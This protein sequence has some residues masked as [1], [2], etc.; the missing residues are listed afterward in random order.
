MSHRYE[1]AVLK[2]MAL[3]LLN[4][5][6]ALCSSAQPLQKLFDTHYP[7]CGIAHILM[8]TPP[9]Q[10]TSGENVMEC[11]AVFFS[12]PKELWAILDRVRVLLRT[13]DGRLELR[14]GYLTLGV[15]E[16]LVE[17]V[18]TWGEEGRERITSDPTAVAPLPAPTAASGAHDT[19]IFALS[20]KAPPA[21]PESA[22]FSAT[23]A[24]TS[25][26]AA[27]ALR[28]EEASSSQVEALCGAEKCGEACQTVVVTLLFREIYNRHRY[29]RADGKRDRQDCAATS[30]PL[31]PFMVYQMLVGE[32]A[33]R[34]IVVMECRQ[35]GAN[36]E[37]RVLVELENADVAGHVIRVFTRRAVE[38]VSELPTNSTKPQSRQL[39]QKG[40]LSICAEVRYIVN[41][42]YS[43]RKGQSRFLPN[44]DRNYHR[45]VAVRPFCSAEL[46]LTNPKNLAK[47]QV[48][49]PRDWK[50][51]P[52]MMRP[53]SMRAQESQVRVEFL[54]E[55]Q[56]SESTSA[57]VQHKRCRSPSPGES[58]G[59]QRRSPSR[60]RSRST[61][62][63]FSRSASVSSSP[64]SRDRYRPRRRHG[65]RRSDERWRTARETTPRGHPKTVET[66]TT[67]AAAAPEALSRVEDRP[68]AAVGYAQTPSQLLAHQTMEAICQSARVAP[69]QP[70][71]TYDSHGP[72]PVGW[73][74][75]FSH[76]YQ[77]TYY[78]YRDPNTGVEMT[79]W[80]RPAT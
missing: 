43:V 27:P 13:E 61:R 9:I 36:R 16:V 39:P 72:L 49:A 10:S 40:V 28:K 44:G 38:Y 53:T 76:E 54:K 79:T 34:K 67:K 25:S 63:S 5:P 70:A 60:S 7:N 35:P 77:Q 52:H 31:S 6:P 64:S 56:L 57:A 46:D 1:D 59:R 42:S 73:R 32:C 15:Y 29:T 51:D 30:F 21:A 11:G 58:E 18:V 69:V 14:R 8:N 55:G 23:A 75:I 45:T 12:S 3:L 41:G 4:L 71:V 24:G 19:K 33:P 50:H 48:K 2:G 22:S 47:L 78:A 80:E 17:G 65:R 37:W 26:G 74:P 20:R 66:A 62:A 68:I